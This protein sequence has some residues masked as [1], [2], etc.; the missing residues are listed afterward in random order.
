[1][2]NNYA[3]VDVYGNI[4]TLYGDDNKPK[5]EGFNHAWGYWTA[6]MSNWNTCRNTAPPPAFVRFLDNVRILERVGYAYFYDA[7]PDHAGGVDFAQKKSPALHVTLFPNSDDV[8]G[9]TLG[10]ISPDA[11]LTNVTVHVDPHSPITDTVKHVLIDTVL[12]IIL[13][14]WPY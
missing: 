3:Y 2:P 5:S 9:S 14:H 10:W 13:R 1:M 11:T 6:E 4:V 7:H 8:H 12:P